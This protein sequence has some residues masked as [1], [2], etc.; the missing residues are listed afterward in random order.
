MS[1]EKPDPR[2]NPTI[3]RAVGTYTRSLYT[4]PVANEERTLGTLS[5]INVH[6]KDSGGP[7]DRFSAADM[8]ALQ[9]AA[10]AL[11][12]WITKEWGRLS[13]DTQSLLAD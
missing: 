2:H 7:A 12:F 5:T 4:I 8:A 3:D 1:M 11:S 9:T 10:E 13:G 6:V